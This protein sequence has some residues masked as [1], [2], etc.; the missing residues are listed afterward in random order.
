MANNLVMRLNQ[1]NFETRNVIGCDT[2]G[3]MK[4]SNASRDLYDS[5]DE[6]CVSSM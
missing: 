5:V 1:N 3:E 2:R 4:V 6:Y